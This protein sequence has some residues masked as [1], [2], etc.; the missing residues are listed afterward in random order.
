MKSA[1]E[2]L[3][4]WNLC[5]DDTQI[6]KDIKQIQLDAMKFCVEQIVPDGNPQIA[7][8]KIKTKMKEL[9]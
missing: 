1:E 3:Q 4:E 6:I 8:D 5:A 7:I 9:Q 2:I